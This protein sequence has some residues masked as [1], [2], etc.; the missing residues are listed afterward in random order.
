MISGRQDG[1]SYLVTLGMTTPVVDMY[2]PRDPLERAADP[3]ERHPYLWR[4]LIC[5]R[6]VSLRPTVIPPATIEFFHIIASSVHRAVEPDEIRV[7][8]GNALSKLLP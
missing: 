1:S 3:I 8:L 6:I 7:V 2:K 4:R 5:T